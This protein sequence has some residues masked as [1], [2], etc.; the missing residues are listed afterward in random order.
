[1]KAALYLFVAAA[2]AGLCAITAGVLVLA[3]LG[4]ALVAGG[5]CLLVC[6]AFIR[7]GL[8]GVTSG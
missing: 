5:T 2:L 4:W 1:M 7:A 3:G 8:R 6:A